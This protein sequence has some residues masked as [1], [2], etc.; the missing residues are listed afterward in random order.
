M[1]GNYALTRT[2]EGPGMKR[3]QLCIFAVS[4]AMTLSGCVGL[5]V[6]TPD[7]CQISSLPTKAEVLNARGQPD[8]LKRDD[9]NEETWT[10][11]VRRNTWCGV[12]PAWIFPLPLMLP[13]CDEYD[14][15]TFI[16]DDAKAAHSARMAISGAMV[17]MPMMQG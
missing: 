3:S 7:K 16:G 9:N 11:Y 6:I 13:I 2:R 10:Y 1:G 5:G 14:R 15:Y 4:A 12:V 17:I 8:E